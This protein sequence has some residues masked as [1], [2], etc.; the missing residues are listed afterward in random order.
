P[1]IAEGQATQ[2]VITHNTAYHA[3]DLD[4]YDSDCDELSTAKVALMENLSHY[5]SN[6][7]AEQ[8]KINVNSDLI[9]VK[10]HGCMLSYNHDLCVLNAI[11]DTFTMIG[12]ACH[13]T[14]ITTTAEVPIKKPTDLENDSSKPIVTLV[15]SRKP[16][17]SK[18]TDPV[19]KSKDHMC[20]AYAMG[21]IK[22][23]SHKPK[24][25]DTNQEKLYLLHMDLCGPMHVA[26]VNEKKYILVIV[27]N[28][29][30]FTWVKCL[31]SKDEALDFIIKFLKM[32]QVRLKTRVRRIKTD[33]G[34]KFVNQTLCEYYENVDISHET[35]V[36]DSSWQNGVVERQNHTLIEAAR[37]MLIYAKAPLF[38]WA[39]A[40]ATAYF[41]ELTTMAYEHSSSEPALHEMTPA[42]VSPGLVPNTPPLTPVVHPAP[43]VITSIAEVVA[44][45]P[46]ASTNSPF[47]TTVDQDAPSPSNSQTIHKIQSP[48]ISNDVEKE[49]HDLDVTYMNNDPFFGVEESPKTI[50]FRDDPLYEDSTSQG[51]SSNMRK[52]HTPFE[53]LGRWTKDHHIANMIGD[54]SRFVSTRKQLQTDAMWCFFDGFLTSVE[55]KNFKQAMTEPSWIDAIDYVDMPLVEKSNL[56]EDLQGKP[57]DDTLYRGMIGSLMYLTSS[58][59]D[60]TYAVGLCARYQA[61]PTKKHLNELK[62]VFRYLKGT[63]N[64]GL[65]YSKDTDMS[66]TAYAD[67]NHVGCQDTRS[68]TSESAQF[69]GDKLVSWSSKKKKCTAI[70]STEAE[71][72]ALSGC[73]AQILWMRSQL[74]DYGF[75]FNKIP[76]YCENKS[77]I[78]L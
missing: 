68:S 31:R 40:V 24:S 5:G 45:E 23:K 11:D 27:D 32:I 44:P 71:Y 19:S 28:Y 42:A 57:V 43:E 38:L 8:F 26:S 20:S 73:C 74:T 17:K 35:S 49:N 6:A 65:W 9:C 60:L 61:K 39:E 7:L 4:A 46:A 56:D 12:N 70:S 16:R 64:M 50:T 63:I 72:I 66:L 25:E 78:A 47:L 77:A 22:K 52:T 1:G 3:N 15:Y 30:R 76:L 18:T 59:P 13:L 55:P 67:E 58:R 51:S 53:S 62:R 48:V 10:C 33:N 41:D 54:P 21:K 2:T 34:T 69:I 75:Q 37:T 36:A 29:S 14:R